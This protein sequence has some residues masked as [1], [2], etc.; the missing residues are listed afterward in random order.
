MPRHTFKF[1]L[2]SINTC[3]SCCSGCC[4][5]GGCT[6]CCSGSCYFR[7]THTKVFVSIITWKPI[8]CSLYQNYNFKLSKVYIGKPT[9]TTG[10]RKCKAILILLIC[11]GYKGVRKAKGLIINP[12]YDSLINWV[13]SSYPHWSIKLC[14]LANA[15]QVIMNLS[16]GDA[17]KILLRFWALCLSIIPGSRRVWEWECVF[18]APKCCCKICCRSLF[19]LLVWR[20]CTTVPN[21]L[22]KT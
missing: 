10:F 20:C 2:H 22:K 7:F 15:D 1:P 5:S 4:S 12:L 18:K 6:G 14:S 17:G 19:P 8:P 3:S 9:C 21:K 11:S 13:T 16:R